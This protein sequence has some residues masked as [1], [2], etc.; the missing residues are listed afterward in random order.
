[1]FIHKAQV[2]TFLGAGSEGDTYAAAVEVPCFLDE[3]LVRV[4]TGAG[5]ELVERSMLYAPLN[6]AAVLKPESRVSVN[7]RF[8]QVSKVRYR[9]GGTLFGP[10]NH[11]EVD[12]S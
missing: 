8:G 10:V 6:K 11:L 5:E 7:G 2:E 3:G 4:Q 12:L 9:N 1:M